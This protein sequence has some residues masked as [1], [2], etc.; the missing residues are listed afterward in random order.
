MKIILKSY[1][2]RGD[3]GSESPGST[4][5]IDKA[6]AERLIESG[7]AIAAGPAETAKPADEKHKAKQ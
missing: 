6:E 4:I 3:K 5:D 2:N 7:A 1:Y